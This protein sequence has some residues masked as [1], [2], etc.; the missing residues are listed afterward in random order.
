MALGPW[1]PQ[2]NMA[3]YLDEQRF[4]DIK[5]QIMRDASTQDSEIVKIL[6]GFNTMLGGEWGPGQQ[7]Q[8]ESIQGSI[9]QMA[10]ILMRW[11]PDWWDKMHGGT[12]SVASLASAIADAHRYDPGFTPEKALQMAEEMSQEL[13]SDPMKHRGFSLRDIG[14][15]YGES[16]KRGWVGR[17]TDTETQLAALT[18]VLGAASAVR[19]VMGPAGYDT[20]DISG[21][22]SALDAVAPGASFDFN[23]ADIDIRTGRYFSQRG[24]QFGHA[25]DVAGQSIIPGGASRAELNAQHKQLTEQA[26]KSE[27]G[28]MLLATARM[29]E[30]GMIDK[31]SDAQKMLDAAMDG[32]LDDF[33]PDQ[34]RRTMGTSG[35]QG[36]TALLIAD[37]RGENQSFLRRNPLYRQLVETVRSKQ[38]MFD[39]QRQFDILGKQFAGMNPEVLKGAKGEYLR[40]RGYRGLSH[41]EQLHGPAVQ[42]IAGVMGDA[43]NRAGVEQN[44]AHMG[45]KGPVQR[46]ADEVKGGTKPLATFG[47]GALGGVRKPPTSPTPPP[48]PPPTPATGAIPA[49]PALPTPIKMAVDS[50]KDT[51]IRESATMKTAAKGIPDRDFFGDPSQLGVDKLVDMFIQRHTASRGTHL[52]YRI[53]SPKTGLFS[54]SMR[55]TR[56]PEPGQKR[57]VRQQPVHSHQY[58]AFSGTIGSGYGKGE[59]RQEQRGKVLITKASPTKIE[60]TIATTGAPERFVLMRP[61]KWG[62]REWLLINVTPKKPVPYEKVKYRKLPPEEV[63]PFIA[64]MQAGTSAQAKLDGASSL[65]EL[66]RGG[67]EVLSYRVSE[68]TGRPIVHTERMFGGRP[69]LDIPK[70][71][72]GTVLKGELYAQEDRRGKVSAGRGATDEDVRADAGKRS[73]GPQAIGSLLTSTIEHS[74]AKQK[75]RGLDIKNMIFDIQQLGKQKVD[76][77]STPYAERRKM[78]EEVLPLLPKGKFH[79]AEEAT[80]PEAAKAMWRQIIEGKHPL[81]REGMVFHPPTGKPIKVKQTEEADVHITDIFSGKGKYRGRGAGG[82]GYALEPGGP[83]VGKV[84]SGLSDE[85]RAQLHADPEQYAGRVARIRSQAQHPSGAYRAPS[86]IALHEDYPTK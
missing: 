35:V 51:S 77:E 3:D 63:E 60:Y 70:K 79:L 66:M 81:T 11:A 22:F 71:Y 72:E 28:N 74:R 2:G 47:A 1:Q 45:W 23:Q 54:W 73:A 8:A 9:A 21:M 82:F 6:K 59:V 61:E 14:R 24:G 86:L 33:T 13:L 18:P 49:M 44:M 37:Q 15:A 46:I 56:L 7:R 39:H 5:T 17:G 12:G 50:R 38:T 76:P 85:L 29:S 62:E 83:R 58:G 4:G 75:E 67:A 43:K 27:I 64:Q 53:G 78:I 52:D 65:V 55:P 26:G 84:G 10:P 57:F 40:G 48:T 42:Q 20:G 30:A 16:T 36:R 69:Q 41:Y 32:K 25:M 68:R 19:D 80:T 31:D 34:W